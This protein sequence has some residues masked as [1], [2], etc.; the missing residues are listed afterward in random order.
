MA[1]EKELGLETGLQKIEKKRKLNNKRHSWNS[2]VFGK[3][4]LTWDD[5]AIGPRDLFSLSY[6]QRRGEIHLLTY[7]AVS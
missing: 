3:F 7:Y 1:K 2:F 4:A 6:I 5:Y